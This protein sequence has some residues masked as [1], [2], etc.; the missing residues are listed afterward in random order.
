MTQVEQL[1]NFIVTASFSDM[2]GF[3]VRELK[4]RVLD[5]LGCALG[6]MHNELVRVVKEQIEDFGGRNQCTLIGGGKTAPDRAAFYNCALVR[7]LD[8]ND[9][10]LA[11][12]ETCHPSDNVGATLAAA[13]CANVC[14][15]DFLTGLAL[16]YQI[17]CR[18]CDVAPVRDR[19]F[20]HVT[21]GAYS[22]AGSVAKVLELDSEETANAIAIS[23]AAYN[24]LRVTRTG[25]LSHWKGLAFANM[26]AG[27]TH[28]AFLAMRGVTGPVEIFEGN[29]G[30]ID[31]IAGQFAIDWSQE[32]VESVTRT[33]LKKYNAEMHSQSAIECVIE[34]QR[35]SGFTPDRIQHI[36]IDIF[37]VAHK[38]IGGGEEGAKMEVLTKEQADHSLPYVI[39]VAL[40]D[41]EVTP[42]QYALERILRDDVQTL[43]RKVTVRPAD[44]F[45]ASFPE[46]LP[47]RVTIHLGDGQVVRKEMR[48]YPGFIK[49]PLPWNAVE[50]KFH[51]L[52]EPCADHVLRDAIVSAVA[53]LDQIRISELTGL[54]GE[55][56]GAADIPKA[57]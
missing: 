41:G 25:K 22:V 15:R 24:A 34:L 16:A 40:L 18:L 20:D 44:E 2:S 35:E 53:N 17:Q 39:A 46:E 33:V 42:A 3:A 27:A 50:E 47:C 57:V 26:A 7:Y 11:K 48:T 45:S 21:L 52:A 28:A 31:T 36:E 13:E 30:F 9:S 54:L 23:G 19:G 49:S 32:N 6:A 4:T 56:G 51:R 10:Y 55:V 1:A 43:L 12:G 8:F 38:I 5:A 29:K 14:G 37:D